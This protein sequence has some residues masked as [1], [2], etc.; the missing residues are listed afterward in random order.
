MMRPLG[1]EPTG[2]DFDADAAAV[3]R[4]AGLDIR[5]GRLEDAGFAPQSFDAI[6]I[7]HAIEHVHDPVALLRQ[8]LGLLRPGGVLWIATPNLA[9][10]AHGR[11]GRHWRGLEAPR[12]LVL[13]DRRSLG[14]AIE[15]AASPGTA[16]VQF[17]PS[18]PWTAAFYVEASR[19][20]RAGEHTGPDDPPSRAS[21]VEAAFARARSRLD[22]TL[23]EELIAVVTLADPSSAPHG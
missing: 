10:Y 22:P 6:T 13:F 2:I 5:L 23:G 18:P 15:R 1:W 20:I 12:H 9:S 16:R 14:E 11:Y 4:A 3:G 21:R 8:A 7:C 17:P 19:R